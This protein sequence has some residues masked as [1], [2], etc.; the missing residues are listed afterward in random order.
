MNR[1]P[2]PT[3]RF[4]ATGPMVTRLGLGGEGVLRTFGRDEDAVAVIEKALDQGVTYFDSARAYA[5]S[6]SYYGRLWGGSPDRRAKIFQT[7]KSAARI[8]AEALADLHQSLANLQT[9]RLN[10]WQIHDLRTDADL[11]AIEA[12]GGGLEAFLAARDAGIVDA[13][14]VTGHHDPAVLLQA[15]EN[16]PVDAVLLPVNPVEAVL[17]GFT[18]LVLEAALEKEMAVIAMKV[19][20]GGHF[21]HPSLGIAAEDLIRFALSYPVTVVIVGCAT[22]QE[23]ETA[24]AAAQAGPLSDRRREEITGIFTPYASR[25][26]FYRQFA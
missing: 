12:P 11:R 24:V 6:E 14:G 15:I 10:L 25:L 9:D 19:L 22:P 21:L 26:A 23:V 18:D 17:G 8:Q 13:L 4:G 5:G 16:W 20:G 2:L 3:N 7:S 1:K